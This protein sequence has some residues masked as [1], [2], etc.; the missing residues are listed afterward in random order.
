MENFI[1]EIDDLALSF[2]DDVEK[3]AGVGLTITSQISA[4]LNNGGV[5]AAV[6]LVPNGLEYAAAA[7]AAIAAL[8]PALTELANKK[9]PIYTQD[10]VKALLQRLGSEIT[11]IAHGGKHPFSFYVRAFETIYAK[12]NKA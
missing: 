8:T 11:S 6:S 2:E 9:S 3:G 4:L 5:I 1:Q 7:K 10:G 12:A